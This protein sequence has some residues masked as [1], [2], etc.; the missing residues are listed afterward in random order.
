MV[1]VP[2]TCCIWCWVLSYR[3]NKAN[4]LLLSEITWYSREEYGEQSIVESDE[5]IQ[6]LKL[7][8]TQKGHKVVFRR[9]VES[10]IGSLNEAQG[11]SVNEQGQDGQHEGM[12]ALTGTGRSSQRFWGKQ[13]N[14]KQ[15][16]PCDPPGPE[17]SIWLE[18]PLL[19]QTISAPSCYQNRSDLF[20]WDKIK[21]GFK[22]E[23]I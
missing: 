2:V 22:S 17:S 5:T 9:W 4:Q 6:Y 21:Q 14:N 19:L 10:Q 7:I 11:T 12:E 23:T 15:T 20:Q 16:R 1:W 8:N 3:V 18:C 13:P